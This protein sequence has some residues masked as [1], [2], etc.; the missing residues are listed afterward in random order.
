MKVG[1][2]E[3]KMGE[4]RNKKK[5]YDAEMKVKLPKYLYEYVKK[6]AKEKNI[7]VSEWVRDLLF[8]TSKWDQI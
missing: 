3:G 1:L 2:L 5:Y 4:L 7:T 6:R 8:E